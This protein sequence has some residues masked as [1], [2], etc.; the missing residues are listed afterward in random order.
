MANNDGAVYLPLQHVKKGRGKPG[1]KGKDVIVVDDK[2]K[3]VGKGS[4]DTKA[5]K[6]A[7][8]STTDPA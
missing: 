3:E 2:G 6:A 7:R 1:Y 8:G 5:A 4:T